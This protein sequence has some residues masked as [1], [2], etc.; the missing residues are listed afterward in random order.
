MT[1]LQVMQAFFTRYGVERTYWVAFS[2]G[3]DSQV[4][5]SLCHQAN[6]YFPLKLCAI[7][8]NHQISPNADAWAQHCAEIC[9]E[10]DITYLETR[11]Q[12]DLELGQS[13]EEVARKKRYAQ[14]VN[15]LNPNDILLTAHHEDDQAETFLLQLFRGAG[16]KGLAAMPA[17]KSFAQGFHARPLLQFS[18]ADLEKYAHQQQLK[19]IDDESNLNLQL[20]RNYIRHEV[21]P[22]LK[23]RWSGISAV[24]SRSASHC[25]EAQELLEEFAVT[26]CQ[27][28]KGTQK[29]TLSVTKLLYLNPAKQKLL[30]RSW[31]KQRGYVLPNSRKMTTILENVLIAKEDRMPYVG[32]ENV[33]LRRYRDELYLIPS[34]M[35]AHNLKA[36]YSWDLT[37]TLILP[38][39]GHLRPVLV[40]GEGLK[41]HIKQ[42]Y[43]RF[44]RGGEI[45]N[46][47]G[48]GRQSLK[49]LF[50]EWGIPP[51]ERQRVPFIY[52]GEQLIGAVG[53]FIHP[54]FKAGINE[55]GC[56][57]TLIQT[58]SEQ[59][60]TT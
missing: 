40:K 22:L 13:V 17:F 28:V 6:D 48:R 5:L 18:R 42:V 46:I 57:I 38:G 56:E 1:L 50:Q 41:A 39:I 10:W 44:R 8:I 53:L 54:D 45:A 52:L 24:I 32:W 60:L 27:N 31:I 14:F 34:S 47:T 58:L 37:Q 20:T 21:L 4:L 16:P 23:A 12:I 51:W 29:N 49:K 2:G 3:L 11:I 35:E 19:W 43:I 33:E 55:I 36:S 9:K 25:A 7:H 30:I 26:E 59:N 15:C